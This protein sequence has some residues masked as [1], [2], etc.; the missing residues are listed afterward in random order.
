MAITAAGVHVAAIHFYFASK[1]ALF[2]AIFNRRVQPINAARL[3]GLRDTRR[4]E[5]LEGVEL[6]P[7]TH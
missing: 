5:R 7:Q 1:E 4:G 6:V 3:A 2:E